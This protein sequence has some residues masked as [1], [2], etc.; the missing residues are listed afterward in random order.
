MNHQHN[1]RFQ[2]KLAKFLWNHIKNDKFSSIQSKL[3][4]FYKQ[5][6]KWFKAQLFTIPFK[7]LHTYKT[8]LH[9]YGGLQE[10]ISKNWPQLW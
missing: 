1:K 8:D 5:F 2:M 6:I 3:K 9:A 10:N 7:F 4:L